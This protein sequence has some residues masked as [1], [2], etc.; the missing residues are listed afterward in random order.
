[1]ANELSKTL[2]LNPGLLMLVANWCPTWWKCFGGRQESETMCGVRNSVHGH[3]A[4]WKIL[5][6]GQADVT[7]DVLEAVV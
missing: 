7:K 3:Q 4:E 2:A 5:R 1:M 6:W